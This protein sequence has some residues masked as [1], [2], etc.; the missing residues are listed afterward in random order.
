[1]EGFDLQKWLESAQIPDN[2]E[3]MH[4]EIKKGTLE[5]LEIFKGVSNEI[6]DNLIE[7]IRDGDIVMANGLAQDF[8]QRADLLGFV[9]E[10]ACRSTIMSARLDSSSE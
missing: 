2:E 1:M 10:I 4:D 3:Q 8:H 6:I 9:V 5:T 7:A